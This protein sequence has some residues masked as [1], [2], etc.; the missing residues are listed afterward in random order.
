MAVQAAQ[1]NPKIFAAVAVLAGGGTVRSEIVESLPPFLV[2]AGASDFG[3]PMAQS[4][5]K[6]LKTECKIY[7]DCEHLTVVQ[8]ALDDVVRFFQKV[9]GF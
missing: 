5:A 8:D 4:L 2:G 7:P 6:A 9:G 3:K 1:A